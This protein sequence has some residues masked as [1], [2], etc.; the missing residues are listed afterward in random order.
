MSRFQLMAISVSVLLWA[1]CA[2]VANLSDKEISQRIIG[3]WNIPPD[4]VDYSE[5]KA[6]GIETFKADGTY[7]LYLFHDPACTSAR[8]QINVYWAVENGLLITTFSD[9]RKI[10]DEVVSIG[11]G[12]MILRS[13]KDGVTFIRERTLRCAKALS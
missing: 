6:W 9:G 3:S 7:V 13:L 12:R 8:K 2:A 1:P 10:R 11:S 4:S 5:P